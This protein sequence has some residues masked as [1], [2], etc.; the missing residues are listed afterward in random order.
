MSETLNAIRARVK[1]Y[2]EHGT[3]GLHAPKDRAALLDALESVL[4]YGEDRKRFTHTGNEQADMAIVGYAGH[5][6]RVIAQALEAT[7]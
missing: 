4:A 5:I 7:R 2:A 1:A 6:E 3:P